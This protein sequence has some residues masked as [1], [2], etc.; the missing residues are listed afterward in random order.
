[1]SFFSDNLLFNFLLTKTRVVTVFIERMG[2]VQYVGRTQSQRRI[3]FL[4][5]KFSCLN[6]SHSIIINNFGYE[7]T[8]DTQ[9]LTRFMKNKELRNFGLLMGYY[10]LNKNQS[11]RSTSFFSLIHWTDSSVSYYYYYPKLGSDRSN[12]K[13]TN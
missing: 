11:K 3:R 9:F 1:M 13:Y 6:L 10:I 7:F 8:N 5:F 4:L 2:A 12:L